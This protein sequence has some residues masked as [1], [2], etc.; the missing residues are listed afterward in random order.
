MN[1]VIPTGV[2]VLVQT[3]VL[4][5][6]VTAAIPGYS[7]YFGGSSG[8]KAYAV[9]LDT[10]GN[11]YIVGETQSGDYP[12]IDCY[13]NHIAGNTDICLSVFS[14]DGSSLL[15]SGYIGG[16]SND[17][18]YAIALDADRNIYVSGSSNSYNFP[19]LNSIQS[20]LAG[21][22]D[23]VVVKFFADGSDVSYSTFLGGSGSDKGKGITV[24][25]GGGVYITGSL[26]LPISRRRRLFRELMGEEVKTLF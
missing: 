26:N 1:L 14:S 6:R 5:S 7:T 22:D 13:Q 3:A 20:Y 8:E 17:Y 18:G 16:I 25:S 19:T 10:D 11:S 9:T 4:I 24:D 15:I 12:T 21:S 2:V 23:A